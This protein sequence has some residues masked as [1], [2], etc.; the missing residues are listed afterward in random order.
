MA[1]SAGQ[2]ALVLSMELAL[3][4]LTVGLVIGLLMSVLQAMTQ[5]QE[6]MLSFIPKILAMAGALLFLLPWLLSRITAYTESVLGRL[7]ALPFS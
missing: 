1:V 6:Q 2:K 3:P 5:V 7:G 4:L